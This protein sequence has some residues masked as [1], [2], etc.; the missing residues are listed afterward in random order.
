MDGV[1]DAA[2]RFITAKYGKPDVITTEFISVDGIAYGAMRLFDDFIYH[3]IERPVVAQIFGIEPEYFYQA[4]QIICELGFD[5]VDINMGCPAKTVSRRGA[6]A[7]L[8]L[9]PKLAQEIVLAVKSGV[10]DWR[11]SGLSNTISEKVLTEMRSTKQKLVDLG[12]EFTQ[13]RKLIPVSVKTRIGYSEVQVEEW[14]PKL[15]E[16]QP[17]S[18]AVHGRTLKQMYQGEADWQ[19]L[20]MVGQ[21][22]T[23]FNSGRRENEQVNYIANGDVDSPEIA[24]MRLEQSKADGLYIGRGSYGN[25]WIFMDIKSYLSGNREVSEERTLETKAKVAYEH[26]LLHYKLKGESGFV[27]MRKHLAWYLRGFPGAVKLRVA[28]MQ[29]NSPVEVKAVLNETLELGL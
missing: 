3:Q 2:F 29:A 7:G 5:G 1:S 25:P 11:Q 23:D 18:I 6:G 8:I 21:I 28:L 4:A 27:Q 20:S 10:A 17:A 19:A 14:I 9:N 15:L 12:V 16:V 13:D 22:I 26:A 24:K